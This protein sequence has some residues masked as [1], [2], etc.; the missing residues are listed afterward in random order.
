MTNVAYKD[1][2]TIFAWELMNEPRCLSDPSG[3]TLQEWIQEMAFYV[4]SID[5]KHLLEI[6][7]EGFYGP[8]SPDRAIFNPNSFAQQVGTDFI[9]NH[10]AL[11]I[12]FAS[13]HI[14]PDS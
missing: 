11:G 8:S 13:V 5:P 3:D 4:K 6:G 9:R 7:V 12:D 14:Y 2:P 1:D 10:Q